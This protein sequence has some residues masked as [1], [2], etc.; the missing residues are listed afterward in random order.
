MSST[1][2]T[3]PV[4]FAQGPPSKKKTFRICGF[5]IGKSRSIFSKS[6]IIVE[7][8]IF[9]DQ[10]P[11]WYILI[12]LGDGANRRKSSDCTLEMGMAE[13]QTQPKEKWKRFNR[14]TTNQSF[15]EYR[16][17]STSIF[18]GVVYFS[19]IKCVIVQ[20]LLS[21]V[22]NYDCPYLVCAWK[23][24]P[25]AIGSSMWT[26][27]PYHPLLPAWTMMTMTTNIVETTSRC[28][29]SKSTFGDFSSRN[30]GTELQFELVA[31][32]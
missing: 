2:A 17:T 5:P 20:T 1:S 22:F 8:P 32:T 6:N 28:I 26:I 13:Q 31:P 3:N 15:K 16:G 14:S 29:H 23:N 7:C 12:T 11:R 27:I 4:E 10:I 25:R 30:W 24:R 19:K 18:L 9:S 21:V